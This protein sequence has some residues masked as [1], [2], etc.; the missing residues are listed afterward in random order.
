[1]IGWIITVVPLWIGHAVI[2]TWLLNNLY[3]RNINKRFLR[4]WRLLTGVVI[5]FGLPAVAWL[6]LPEELE[7]TRFQSIIT[8]PLTIYFY[9]CQFLGLVVFP[10]L[11]IWRLTRPLPRSLHSQ[12]IETVDYWKELGPTVGGR[13]KWWW[14]ARLPFTCAFRVD[15]A[16]IELKLPNLPKA[17][18]GLTILHLSDFHFH[19]TPARQWFERVNRDIAAR[20][21]SSDL[22]VLTGDYIDTDSHVAWIK[23]LLEGYAAT[24]GKL[25]VLGNHDAKHHPDE[26]RK[27]LTVA[28]YRVVSNRWDVINIHGE[29]CAVVGNEGPW[30]GPPP[31]PYPNRE[32]PKIALL[33][34]PDNIYWAAREGCQLAFAGHVHGGQVRL[35]IIGPIF[36][37]SIYSRRFDTGVFD[38]Q[39]TTLVISRGLSGKEPL[40][41][42][43][44]PQIVRVTL[45]TG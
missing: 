8:P 23:P 20:W 17:W 10:L 11:T 15:F 44:N 19:G 2:W 25:A 41:F 38:V 40:R 4:I 1:M 5:L 45:R 16:E 36:V 39:G 27:A 28:G 30:L 21:P 14:M 35:P 6:I 13:G 33:H 22:V 9:L 32:L 18:D 31:G 26:V 24:E 43:C 34:S 29:S 37:P 42:R 7:L 3:G 12:K